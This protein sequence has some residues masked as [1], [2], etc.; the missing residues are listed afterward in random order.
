MQLM[1]GSWIVLLLGL[2]S[3]VH[4]GQVSYADYYQGQVVDMDTGKP[5]QGVLVVFIWDRLV[6]SPDTK[7]TSTEI[8]AVTEVFTDANGRFKVSAAPETT[9]LGSFVVEVRKEN[10][11]FFAPGYFLA[12]KG[13]SEG[14]PLRDPTTV[15]MKRTDNPK[16]DLEGLARSFPSFPYDRTPLLL[17]ALNA[18]R[19]RLGLPP[20]QPGKE[21]RGS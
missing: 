14:K 4:A 15:Y 21:R 9:N 19:V 20:I 8:H 18:E 5:I 1:A 12:Y 10:P 16:N 2:T 3:C 17:K 13:K 11:V 7:R 6:Y